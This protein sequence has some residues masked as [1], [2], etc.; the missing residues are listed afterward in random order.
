MPKTRDPHCVALLLLCATLAACNQDR[1]AQ[2]SSGE[3]LQDTVGTAREARASLAGG[4]A[5][6]AQTYSY[7]G[8]Y[9]GMTRSRLEAQ[10]GT[11][12]PDS[13]CHAVATK[14]HD[15]LLC[16]YDAF[17]QP[18]TAHISVDVTYPRTGSA[19]PL[20]RIVS[21]TRQ[22]PLDVDGVRLAQL[23]ADAFEKQTSLLD[24]R[25]AE[26]GP[27][28]AQVRMGTL[29]GARENYADVSIHVSNGREVLAVKLSR[30]DPAPASQTPVP[31]TSVPPMSAPPTKQ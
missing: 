13:S 8:L 27:H 12:A 23:L 21:V 9:A 6:G 28:A 29:R 18:D 24:K 2:R 25:E 14:G 7:R 16:S 11:T 20:A 19:D 17:V 30:S 1:T 26:Y 31:P 3:T 4:I 10:L 22:L 15:D 5:P